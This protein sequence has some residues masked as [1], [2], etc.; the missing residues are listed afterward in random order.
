MTRHDSLE[1]DNRVREMVLR[2]MRDFEIADALGIS[3]QRVLLL[4]RRV[5]LPPNRPPRSRRR[6]SPA[7]QKG[8]RFT[9]PIDPTKAQQITEAKRRYWQ[10]A[11]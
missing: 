5:G 9:S 10:G 3:R 11:A 4:R 7:G 2:G 6:V 1:R 8:R